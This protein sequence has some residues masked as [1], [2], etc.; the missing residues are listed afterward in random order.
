MRHTQGLSLIS[1]FQ[2]LKASLVA[3]LNRWQ[4]FRLH[5]AVRCKLVFQYNLSHR[6]YFG[7]VL[8]DHDKGT[9]QLKVC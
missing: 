8:F 2:R 3:R 7:K 9:L 1:N 5:I 4:E 6:G